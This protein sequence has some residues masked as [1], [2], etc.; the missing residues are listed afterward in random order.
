[1]LKVQNKEKHMNAEEFYWYC[2]DEDG[3]NYFFSS[4]QLKVAKDRALKNKEDIPN[5]L[6]TS[7]FLNG[8][9]VGLFAGAGV[10]IIAYLVV[11]KF[12]I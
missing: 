5:K 12:V 2:Q 4:S 1:M 7:K 6:K 8:V 11:Q 10:C 9:L 3:T